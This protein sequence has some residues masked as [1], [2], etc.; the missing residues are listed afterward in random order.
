M[1]TA[2]WSASTGKASRRNERRSSAFAWST[3]FWHGE[4]HLVTEGTAVNPWAKIAPHPDFRVLFVRHAESQINIMPELEIPRHALPPDSGVT[5]PLTKRGMQQAKALAEKL[6]GDDLIAVY[7]ST[8][9]RC[10][11]TATALAVPHELPVAIAEE[12]VEIAFTDPAASMG[13]IEP[14]EVAAVIARWAE[15]DIDAAAPG[16]ES[17]RELFQRFVPFV[18]ETIANHAGSPGIL[19][20]VSHGGAL[21]AGLTQVFPNIS[22]QFVAGHLFDNTQT[23]TGQFVDGRLVCI[24][25]QGTIPEMG[26]DGSAPK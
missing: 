19:I 11:Q 23:A 15:G 4:G 24:D 18:T 6:E 7:T 10:I 1:S 5:Y 17:L 8:R 21:A 25:W 16:G 14:E 13:M 3:F 2:A 22:R 20:F 26:L 9:M 12:I